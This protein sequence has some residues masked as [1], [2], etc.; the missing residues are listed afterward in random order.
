MFQGG[1]NWAFASFM[2]FGAGVYA[3]VNSTQSPVGFNIKLFVG[4]MGREKKPKQ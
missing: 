4:K 1:I 2:G 3:N